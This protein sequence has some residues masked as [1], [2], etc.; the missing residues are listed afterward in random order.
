MR[1]AVRLVLVALLAASSGCILAGKQV[2][3]AIKG[4]SGD[5]EVRKPLARPFQTFQR[6]EI[7][8]FTNTAGDKV[9]KNVVAIL[10][11]EIKKQ[12]MSIQMDKK[13][14]FTAVT[15]SGEM[16]GESRMPT[17]IVRGSIADY[18]EG[19]GAGRVTGWV[20]ANKLICEVEFVD[21]S[22]REVLLAAT[23]SGIRKTDIGR[24]E[25]DTATGVGK[26]I[27]EAIEDNWKTVDEDYT[28]VVP[29]EPKEEEKK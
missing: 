1:L 7:A 27:S 20:G 18:E 12:V 11:Q 13:P 8:R 26:G 14:A 9:P 21:E 15:M 28:K 19:S 16:S 22:T 3:Y 17:L 29:R 10:E 4:S 2:F 24:D 23:I 5:I 25:T 6:C